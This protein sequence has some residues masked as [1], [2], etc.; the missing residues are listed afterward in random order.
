MK[1][2]KLVVAWFYNFPREVPL[3]NAGIIGWLFCSKDDQKVKINRPDI[4]KGELALVLFVEEVVLRDVL[5]HELGLLT[6]P[7]GA[8][9]TNV[10]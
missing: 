7:L 4:V 1:S 2:G 8:K 10:N 6:V 9:S 3:W 5:N